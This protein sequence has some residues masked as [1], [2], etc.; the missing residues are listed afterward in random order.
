MKGSLLL[1]GARLMT[2]TQRSLALLKREGYTCRVV[3]RW[4]PHVKI[5]QDLLGFDILGIQAGKRPLLVQ[6]GVQGAIGKHFEKIL[7]LPT[8]KVLL[9]S[10]DLEIHGWR[11][12]RLPRIHAECDRRQIVFGDDW[13]I[14]LEPKEGYTTRR[15]KVFRLRQE[16]ALPF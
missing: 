1:I 7:A 2:P 12:L 15:A 14:F 13:N 3:E 6:T 16:G 4:N 11:V 10:H 9:E 5:R 8:T